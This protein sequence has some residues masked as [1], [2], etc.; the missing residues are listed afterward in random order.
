L[1]QLGGNLFLADGGGE[2]EALRTIEGRTALREHLLG[3]Q[4]GKARRR[5]AERNS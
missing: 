1:P 5:S 4:H 2:G 3:H